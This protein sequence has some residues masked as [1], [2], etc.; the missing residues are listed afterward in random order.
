MAG[1]GSSSS[2]WSRTPTG[3]SFEARST[4]EITVAVPVQF[5]GARAALRWNWWWT[6]MFSRSLTGDRSPG[7]AKPGLPAQGEA[8]P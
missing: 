8:L 5:W 3:K 4:W 2:G 6:R 1:A 7:G